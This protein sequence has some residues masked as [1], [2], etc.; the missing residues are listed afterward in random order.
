VSRTFD[1]CTRAAPGA[2]DCFSDEAY[3]EMRR[4]DCARA[5]SLA[6]A[7][8]VRHGNDPIGYRHLADAVAGRGGT[9]EAVMDLIEAHDKRRAPVPRY[10]PPMAAML[11][12]LRGDFTAA[13]ARLEAARAS[14]VGEKRTAE[15]ALA[16]LSAE[17]AF[18]GKRGGAA[19]A[20]I[21]RY[22]RLRSAWTNPM[23]PRM[24]YYAF[25]PRLLFLRAELG[26]GDASAELAQWRNGI[27]Q[28]RAGLAPHVLW[29]LGPGLAATTADA[30]RVALETM[31]PLPKLATRAAVVD[32]II[33]RT[34]RLAGRTDEAIAR[35]ELVTSRC[36]LLEEP[37][38]IVRADLDLGLAL[39]AAGRTRDAC[40]SY[41]R[42][43]ERWRAAKP[44]SRTTEAAAARSA[45]LRCGAP[46]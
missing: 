12:V 38:E 35:L 37:L 32:A 30:A 29:A 24:K 26:H 33:G 22:V 46:R 4:G 20:T 16:W 23:L 31:P 10:E 25:E 6:R 42:I 14:S 36:D 9:P 34:L 15:I 41:A 45:A 18:E 5:E 8:V 7:V 21:E 13:E 2:V 27:A 19:A 17:I 11:D 28:L 40:K 43:L 3:F 1:A 44:A 39:E